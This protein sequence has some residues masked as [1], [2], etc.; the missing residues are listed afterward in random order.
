LEDLEDLT[1]FHFIG[2]SRGIGVE[3]VKR[4]IVEIYFHVFCGVANIL[5]VEKSFGPMTT[6]NTVRIDKDGFKK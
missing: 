2:R 5:G 1:N 6:G 4:V 3:L